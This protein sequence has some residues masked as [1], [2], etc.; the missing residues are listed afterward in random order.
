MLGQSKE[1]QGSYDLTVAHFQQQ[2]GGATMD[3]IEQM[4]LMAT[5]DAVKQDERVRISRR[6]ENAL[7]G[8]PWLSEET[9]RTIIRCCGEG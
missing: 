1:W 5:L 2:S 7:A 3:E 9:R 8:M 6:L 4:D